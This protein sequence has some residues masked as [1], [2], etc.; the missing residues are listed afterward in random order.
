MTKMLAVALSLASRKRMVSG[1][2]PTCG[3]CNSPFIGLNKALRTRIGTKRRES[4]QLKFSGGNNYSDGLAHP[5]NDGEHFRNDDRKAPT[6]SAPRM[7]CKAC[8][9]PRRR[10]VRELQ[11]MPD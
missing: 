9:T 2:Q 3:T 6:S 8:W 10:G 4:H 5:L 11:R 7:P 1:T